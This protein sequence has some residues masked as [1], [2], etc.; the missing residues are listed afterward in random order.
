MTKP[1]VKSFFDESTNTISHIVFD[2]S[3]KDAVIIDPVLAYDAASGRTDS[4]PA[5]ILVDYINRHSL[6]IRYIIETH[7]HADHLSS[8]P[9]LKEKLGGKITIGK[10]IDMVQEVF[11]DV[12]NVEPE[13]KRDGSQF[14]LLLEDGQELALGKLSITAIHTPGHTPA[15]MSFLIGDALFAGD[16]LFMPDFGTARCDFPGGDAKT[17]YRSIQKLFELPDTTRV[18]LCHDYKAPGRDVYAW[19]TT[20]GEQ[21]AHN[22]HVG[23]GKSEDEFVAMRTARDATLCM[24]K[25]ILPSVQINMRAGHM[26]PA[27]DNGTHFIKIPINIL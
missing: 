26:P 3:S 15:C 16:T 22:I 21:K 6:K 8:A 23:A 25:L 5:D 2:A 13:F 12:F 27:E 24:P 11:G 10:H 7:A 14:D 19:E 1:D 17:L 9:Y 4:A 20:I 18:F